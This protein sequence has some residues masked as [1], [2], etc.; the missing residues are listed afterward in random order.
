MEDTMPRMGGLG[1]HFAPHPLITV[2]GV[3]YLHLGMENGTDLY[4]TAHRPPSP[5][6]KGRRPMAQ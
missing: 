4:V 5:P 2:L 3:K 6:P 1:I